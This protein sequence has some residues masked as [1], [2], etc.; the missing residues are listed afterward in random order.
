MQEWNRTRE[1]IISM[2]REHNDGWM[3]NMSEKLNIKYPR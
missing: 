2:Y 3:K 1:A